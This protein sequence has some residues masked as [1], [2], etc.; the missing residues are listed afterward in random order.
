MAVNHGNDG[1]VQD[2]YA[3]NS[4]CLELRLMEAVSQM[5]TR[6]E[7]ISKKSIETITVDVDTMGITKKMSLE[8]QT[9]TKK[10]EAREIS[11]ITKTS[12]SMKVENLKTQEA[13][14]MTM[15]ANEMTP[16]R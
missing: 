9:I 16:M 4:D 2:A 7:L 1:D 5:G 12:E 13:M 3:A 11:R 6:M 14:K 8:F 10:M 15:E